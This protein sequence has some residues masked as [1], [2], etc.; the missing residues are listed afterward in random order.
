MPP[1]G[2]TLPRVPPSSSPA[3]WRT[4][5]ATTSSC[6]GAT[7]STGI[8]ATG[9]LGPPG[10]FNRYVLR[11]VASNLLSNAMYYSPPGG[12]V[13]C[14]LE[15][16]GV[17]WSLVVEN[18]A[19]DLGEEDLPSLSEP[20]GARTARAPAATASDCAWLYRTSS[21]S[22]RE[23]GSASSSKPRPSVR[24]SNKAARLQRKVLLEIDLIPGDVC[25]AR[26][27]IRRTCCRRPRNRARS[28]RPRR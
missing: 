12:D 14:R 20:L 18:L 22:G 2:T 25:R 9:V 24:S 19:P 16:Q 21:P 26:L 13:T 11:I 1:A 23:C 17:H 10:C 3:H 28:R 6:H 27:R 8:V 4:R 5:S 15:R 7:K